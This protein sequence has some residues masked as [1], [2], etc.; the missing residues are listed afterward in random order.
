MSALGN[1]DWITAD[2]SSNPIFTDTYINEASA[3]TNYNT[4][5]NLKIKGTKGAATQKATILD[6]TIPEAK[7]LVDSNSNDIPDNVE[8]AKIEMRLYC[9]TDPASDTH[10][11][12]GQKL[13]TAAS[14]SLVDWNTTDG[15]SGWHP[16]L[17]GSGTETRVYEDTLCTATFDTSSTGWNTFTFMNLFK[18]GIKFGSQ[19]QMILYSAGEEI[20]FDSVNKSGGNPPSL[21]I[22]FRKPLPDAATISIVPDAYGLNGFINI[23]E[24]TADENLQK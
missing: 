23:D 7:D 4:D 1:T 9:T 15:T 16:D 19:F 20:I 18:N 11:V 14:I 24:H 2:Q 21:K 8:F 3:G 17:G 6:I 22:Y 5:D 10:V 12:A 13:T